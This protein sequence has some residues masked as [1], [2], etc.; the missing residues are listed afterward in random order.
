MTRT[1]ALLWSFFGPFLVLFP[2]GMVVAILAG[3]AH[4]PTTSDSMRKTLY[5][6][7]ILLGIAALIGGFAI[8]VKHAGW[9]VRSKL[10]PEGWKWISLLGVWGLIVMLL[11][12]DRAAL[13]PAA[14]VT[15]GPPP[16]TNPTTSGGGAGLSNWIAYLLVALG[17]LL[18]A[19]MI[20]NGLQK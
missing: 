20:W 3:T 2:V 10:Q 8:R 9:Y 15:G 6:V 13:A 7:C 4:E 1:K 12:T 11:L 18:V 19:V 5:T 14:P 16:A 17:V